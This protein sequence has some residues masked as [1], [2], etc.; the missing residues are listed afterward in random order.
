[1]LDGR[2][3][4]LKSRWWQRVFDVCQKNP[5]SIPIFGFF[6]LYYV[7]IYSENFPEG[8]LLYPLRL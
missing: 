5:E 1:M 6:L 7:N 3:M 4:G 8:M 2:A